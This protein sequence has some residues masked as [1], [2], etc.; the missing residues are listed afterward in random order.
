MNK[1]IIALTLCCMLMPSIASPGN[2]AA[3]VKDFISVLTAGAPATVGD[4]GVV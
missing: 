4:L 3:G 2:P 1:W